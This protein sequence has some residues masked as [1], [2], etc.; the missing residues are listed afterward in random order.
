[1]TF[2]LRTTDNDETFGDQARYTFNKAGLLVVRPGD[3]RQI[4]YS[5][6]AWVDIDEPEAKSAMYSF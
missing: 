3:G 2:T 6:S 1:M 5:P 4:T